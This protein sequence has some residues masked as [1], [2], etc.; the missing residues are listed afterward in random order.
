VKEIFQ[1]MQ[2]LKDLDE[3]TLI[4]IRFRLRQM[5]RNPFEGIKVYPG[6]FKDCN[7]LSRLHAADKRD[8]YCEGSDNR[9]F[10]SYQ[11]ELT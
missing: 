10:R 3:D 1:V 6:C 8:I 7:H 5:V 11:V 9:D 2:D 4:D